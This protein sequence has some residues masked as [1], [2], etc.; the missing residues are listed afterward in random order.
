M[1]TEVGKDKDNFTTLLLIAAVLFSIFVVVYATY[2]T[3]SGINARRSGAAGV[4]CDVNSDG[5]VNQDDM[6]QFYNSYF[7]KDPLA[8]L[9]GDG[10]INP[11]DQQAIEAC[12][13]E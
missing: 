13:G 7:T 4:N 12:L 6:G 8:D 10:S 5:L 1:F 3:R 2:R 9:N 11:L